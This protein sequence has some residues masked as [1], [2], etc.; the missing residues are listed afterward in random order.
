MVRTEDKVCFDQLSA[1]D[2]DLILLKE[3]AVKICYD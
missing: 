1:K 3:L 2:S